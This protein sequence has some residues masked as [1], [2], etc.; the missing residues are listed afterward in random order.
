MWKVLRIIVL[1]ALLP[2]VA[3]AQDGDDPYRIN[4]GDV[5]QIS[6]WQ[7]PNMLRE[8]VVLPDGSIS[9]LLVGE[10]AAANRLPA[11][12]E[13]KIEMRLEE[14]NIFNNPLVSVSIVEP[15]GYQVYVLGE[16]G[17]PGVYSMIRRIDVLQALS[18]AGGLSE[19]ADEDG[20]K[21][22][23][24]TN[25]QQEIVEF[26]YSNV[27]EGIGLETNII[28]RSGDTIVVPASTIF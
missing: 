11:E 3:G 13:R 6:V 22:L 12:I 26:N 10:I 23:R 2:S 1:L 16:V 18:L 28:L 24:R 15:R 21:I 8:I 4:P 20:I 14:K 5:L 25:G 27:E 19:F 9:Y 17:N 7:D